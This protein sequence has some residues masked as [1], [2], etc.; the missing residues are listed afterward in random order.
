MEMSGA[1]S[2]FFAWTA[3]I[4][5]IFF[6]KL[7]VKIMFLPENCKGTCEEVAFSR[8]HVAAKDYLHR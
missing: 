7:A 8:A 2:R 5:D 4:K 6:R 1:E 3:E